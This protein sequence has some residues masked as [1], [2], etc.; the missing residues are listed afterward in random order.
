MEWFHSALNDISLQQTTR[1]RLPSGLLKEIEEGRKIGQKIFQKITRQEV[2]GIDAK[3]SKS[4]SY[5]PEDIVLSFSKERLYSKWLPKVVGGG[6]GHPL[7]F[8]GLNYEMGGGCLGISN[9]LGA[10]YVALGLVSATNSFAILAKITEDIVASEK[11]NGHSTVAL[12]VTEPGAGSDMEE[13]ELLKRAKVCTVAKKVSGGY[14]ISGQKIFISNSLFAK[15]LI[16]SSFEDIKNPTGTLLIFAVKANAKGIT[17]G[18][19]EEKMGQGASPANVVFFENVFIPDEDVCFSREQFS[20]EGAFRKN[21]EYLLNDLLSLSRA[22]VGCLATGAQRRILEIMV[23][24]AQ[25]KGLTQEWV[26]NHISQVLQNFVVSKT[27]SW[28]GHVE[29][30]SR[31]PYKDLQSPIGYSLFKYTPSFILKLCLGSLLKTSSARESLRKKRRESISMSDEKM[32]F[33]WGALTKN[34]CSDKAVESAHLALEL[35]GS[36]GGEFFWEMEKL[37]RDLKLLQIYEGTNELNRLMVNKSFIG[38]S[39]EERMIFEESR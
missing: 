23:A 37:L 8:Y 1:G 17:L 38:P 33:G 19:T 4:S 12:A 3:V 32:I 30:Y 13:A 35:I 28:E 25:E 18:R 2:Q 27:V 11:N 10:H 39:E 9:L 16:V 22:G 26:K 31:G 14:S 5:Y 15:W 7:A 29:C 36:D 24:H 21:S 20:D 6:G 34:V